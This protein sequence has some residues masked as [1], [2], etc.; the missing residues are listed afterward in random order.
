MSVQ[1]L[2]AVMDMR[3]DDLTGTR[4]FVLL[5]LANRADADDKCWPSQQLIAD[6]VGITVRAV[7][8]HLAALEE[9]GLISR[10]TEHHG[11]GRGSSTT[12]RMHLRVAFAP[13]EFAPEKFAPEKSDS[14]HRKPAS[15]QETTLEPTEIYNRGCEGFTTFWRLYPRKVGR[16]NAEKAFGKLK[17]LERVE[18]TERL[19]LFLPGWEARDREFIPHAAT[20][21]NGRRWEDEPDPPKKPV[22]K[23]GETLEDVFRDLELRI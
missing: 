21:L 2:S 3:R 7:A 20:W 5:C 4:K 9:M 14:L 23:R 18:A 19:A 12:Y 22:D 6:E 15:C 8:T 1:H 17:P 11:Q 10:T 13:E 16:A